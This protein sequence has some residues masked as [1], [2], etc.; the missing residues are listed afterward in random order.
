MA[1]KQSL[2]VYPKQKAP[3]AKIKFRDFPV[4]LNFYEVVRQKEEHYFICI[5]FSFLTRYFPDSVKF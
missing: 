3:K 2:E 1:N 5:F 4:S